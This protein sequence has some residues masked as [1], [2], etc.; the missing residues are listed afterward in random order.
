MGDLAGNPISLDRWKALAREGKAPADAILHKSYIADNIKALSDDSRKLSFTI[1]T[2]AV[3]RDRDTLRPEGWK[4]AEYRKNPVVLWAHQKMGLPIAKASDVRIEAGALKA[5]AEFV[6]AEDYPFADT[7]Y[8]LL[9]GR[10]LRST[11]VGFLPDFEKADWNEE[12]GGFDFKVQT[13]LEFSVV[14]VPA[15]PEALMDAKAAGID[16]G[17][18]RE[19]AEKW[20]DLNE[21]G[22]WVPTEQ[23]ELARKALAEP[24]IVI[25]PGYLY[26]R[27]GEV[28]LCSPEY[29]PEPYLA[30]TRERLEK[31]GRVL[32]QANEDRIRRA[33]DGAEACSMALDEV[34]SSMP[35]ED[36]PKAAPV[37]YVVPQ[38]KYLVD[39][40]VVASAVSAAVSRSVLQGV[41]RLRGRID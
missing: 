40:T 19:W 23:L 28:E 1:S 32:S 9:K 15:N 34:M 11:S 21:P 5:V 35:M 17:P 27:V 2:G 29:D 3:D 10:F 20:L 41:N 22:A 37:A 7:V 14:P 31:R 18:I 25:P 4:L 39:P 6:T 24:R 30:A 36:E 16:C 38:Q 12:R 8:R 26:R 13:L 33:R